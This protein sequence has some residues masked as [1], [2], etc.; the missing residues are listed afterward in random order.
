MG[1]LGTLGNLIS[2]A[3]SVL[4]M[5]P[6]VGSVAGGIANAIGG[7]LGSSMQTSDAQQY[8]QQ[9]AE[10]NQK[11]QSEEN[12]K[13]RQWQSDE[14]T[15]QFNMN[16]AYNDPS[17]VASRLRQAGI[18][19][20]VAFEN[21]TSQYG[22]GASP[23]APSG[24]SGMSPS[25]D[26]SGVI[27]RGFQSM[28]S[29]ANRLKI[30]NEARKTG[31]ESEYV[32]AKLDAETSKILSDMRLNDAES[33]AKE[34]ALII[35]RQF[36]RVRASKELR[37]LEADAIKS[38]NEAYLAVS[39]GNYYDEAALNQSVQALVQY[40][41]KHNLEVEGKSLEEQLKWLPAKLRAEVD[42]LKAR[43]AQERSEASYKSALAETENALR[44]IQ[45]KIKNQEFKFG[46]DSYYYRL[47]QLAEELKKSGLMNDEL[48]Q[49]V[50]KLKYANDHK[51]F[52]YWSS[53]YFQLLHVG[54]NG[55]SEALPLMMK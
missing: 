39:Q 49:V 37:K 30:L 6:G 40:A 38:I 35:E 27:T 26:Y 21:G 9:M 14:W 44:D 47:D 34:F 29:L 43:A 2:G 7:A 54:T 8:Q 11:W 23:S 10:Q 33:A 18:N 15:R 42:E 25:P 19:P 13:N 55:M 46:S 41:Y 17:A 22:S 1:F 20:Q 3:G 52:E 45:V 51:E 32:G 24:A 5:I 48:R 50:E 31:I 53:K 28:E 36:A 4:G 16:N 12:E